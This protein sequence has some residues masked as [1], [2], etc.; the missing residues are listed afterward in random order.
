MSVCRVIGVLAVFVVLIRVNVGLIACLSGCGLARALIQTRAN[1]RY[2][3]GVLSKFPFLSM[4]L[5]FLPCISLKIA[6]I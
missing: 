5:K 6:L 1:F 2:A 4:N 3:Q